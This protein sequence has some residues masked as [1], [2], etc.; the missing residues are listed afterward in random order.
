MKKLKLFFAC[1]LMSILSIG[2]VW[3]TLPAS[4]TWEAQALADIA[5]GSTVIII[6]NSTTA[7]NIALPAAGAGTSNPPK[8]A[9]TV[10]TTDG[11]ST[12][13]PPTGTT[14]QDLAWTLK[15]KTSTWQFFVEGST[16]NCL[17]LTGTS[18]N[19]ALRV[20]EG[21]S[22]NEFVMGDLDKL[23]KVT[24]AAR[25]VG[26]YDNNGSDWRTYNTENATN[27]KGAQL[28]FYVL[29][30]A[31]SC[32][33]TVTITKGAETNGTYTLSAT[34]ICG[35]GEGEDVTIS[36][37]TPDPGYAFDK[38]TTSASG[39]VDNENKKVTGITA[40]T[41]ITV[42]FKELQKYTVSF[43]TGAGNPSQ[44]DITETTAGAGITLPAG[45]T[46][47]C[48]A[49]G[50]VFAGWA[51]AAVA[52]ETTTAPTLLSGTYHPT[53]DI[54]LY[55]VYKKDG[56]S[57][58]SA[59][60][61]ITPSEFTG[62]GDPYTLS[63]DQAAFTIQVNKNSGTKPTVN[64]TAGDAR[65]YAGS[66]MVISNA[67]PMTELVFNIST[68]GKKRLAPITASVGE[69]ATQASG[70]ETVTWTGNATEVTFTVGASADYGSDG[71][72]KAGQLDFDN[73][74]ATAGSSTIYYL[75]APTCCTKHAVNIAAGIEHG[76]VSADPVS[77]C[78]G[79]TITL[80]F[81]PALNYHLSAWTLNGEAQDIAEN[82]FEMPGADVTVSATFAQ[83]ACEPLGTPSVTVSGKAYP[84]DAVQL[85]WTAIEHADAYKVYIYD[86]EDNELEHNDAFAGVEYTIDQ[87]L[88]A[89]TTY[90][91]SVQAIS[92]TPATYCPSTEAASTFTTDALPT[93]H[94]TLIDLEGEHAESG[95]HP[96]LTPFALPTEAASCSKE[97]Y[98]WTSTENY[99]SEDVA[100][101]YK[102]GDNFTFANTTGVTLYAVYADELTPGTTSYVKT[103]LADIASGSEVVV[104]ELYS[105]TIYAIGNDGGTSTGPAAVELAES[106]TDV[107]NVGDNTNIFWV[108]TK[109]GANFSLTVKGGTDKLY[110]TDT[111]NGVRVGTNENNVFSI[112]SDYIF[113]NAT[114][115]YVG[116]NHGS[117]GLFRCYTTINTNINGETLAFYKKTVGEG[118]YGNY[119]TAC[120][121][122][123]EAIVDP[124]EVSATAAAVA[125]GVIEVAYDNVDEENVSVALFSDAA[126][127]EAFDGGWLTASINGD[128]NIAY[129]IAENTTYVARKAYIKL[130]APETNGATDPA[131]VII[132]VEQAGKATVF[133][134]LEDLVA[135]ELASGTE[136]TVSFSNVMI[137]EV[138]ETNAGYRYGLYL[139]VKDKD[140]E[141]DIEL[142]YN[143][144]GDSE[145]VPDTWVKNGYVSATNLVTTWTEYKGQW[146]LAMQ[147][148]T[149]SWENGDITYGAPKAVS[150][151]VVSGEPTKKAYVDGEKFNP[152]GLTVTVNYTVG[153]PE[154]IAVT[155]ADWE[156]TPER[157][158]KGE[159]EISVKATYNT[160]QSAA[161]NVTGLTVGDIQAKTIAEFIANKGGRCYLEGIVNGNI[162]TNF[163]NFDLTD[164]SGTIYVYGSDVF[165][166]NRDVKQGDKVKVIAEEYLL[167]QKA[168]NPDKDEALNVE[169]VSVKKAATV[170]FDDLAMEIEDVATIEPKAI[171][172]AEASAVEY[173]IKDGSDNCI[174]LDGAQI[175]ATAAGTATIVAT[176]AE[177]TA[178]MGTT[179]EFTVTVTEKDTRK[180]A[181]GSAFTAT[182]GD[183]SPA[184]IKFE[185]FKGDNT[186]NNPVINNS[187]IRLYKPLSGTTGN[188][189]TLT[190]K[191]GCKIDQV[192]ITFGGN[193]DAS[194]S[195]D[196]ADFPTTKYITG[197]T[198]LLT[199][200]GLNAQS[201]S[202]VNMKNGSIDVSAIKVWYTGDPLAIDHYILGGTYETTFEQYGAFD[203]TGLQV[204]A[205]YDKEETITEEIFDFTVEADLMTA[206][207]KKAEVYLNE[208]K[209]AEYDITVTQTDK[210]DPEIGWSPANNIVITEGNEFTAPTWQNPHSVSVSFESTNTNVASVSNAG[211]IAIKG[212]GTTTITAT[213]D[214]DETYYSANP[215][216]TVTVNAAVEDLSGDWV[217]ATSVAAGDRIIIA[218]EAEQ[219]AVK[220]M[221]AQN[222]SYREEVAS[223]VD[224][225]N[226]LTP[227]A[228][229]K[230]FTLVDASSFGSYEGFALQASNG[231]YLSSASNSSNNIK[232]VASV[233]DANA[234]WSI[235]ISEGVAA[236]V[237]QGSYTRKVI[238]YNGGSTRFSCYAESNTM[239]DVVIYKKGA[240]PEPV[241]EI[242]RP[243]LTAGNYYT[244]CYNKTMTEI[245]GASLWSFAGKDASMA[246]LVEAEKP[247]AAGTPY[248]IYAESD[249]L[250]A[251][252]EEVP[253]PEAGSNNGLYGTF[254]YMDASALSAA[255]ATYMLYNNALR[256]IGDN[257]HLDANRA[258]VILGNI[259]GGA[260]SAAQVQGR[261][262]RQMP[263]QGQTATGFGELNASETPVKMVINGQLFILRGEKMYD[264]TG[265]LVK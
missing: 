10:S 198:E 178:Y 182:S 258:Y 1:L 216:I 124:E 64:A 42:L 44:A 60:V 113:N 13:T 34:E 175:T 196:G 82:T 156:S 205:A 251:V 193:A 233:S 21:T 245:H 126:C 9:C 22:N 201:V 135:A 40:N 50:W 100:P 180:V 79:A 256:P 125:A 248:F 19:T 211:V 45:P 102:A 153:D 123:P 204:F 166:D 221:G 154:V 236:I 78:E 223:T 46:P 228:G 146:E 129:T 219:G 145:Q 148:A 130:T 174:T 206:G 222:G 6:S 192:Q 136:V 246:Y 67:S 3:A 33:N 214:G 139:N 114:S 140:G 95:D 121:A 17:Y 262:V 203:Y 28:T 93:A 48:S 142:F 225:E 117:G 257:N 157:L 133:A 71:S 260:P 209:I 151:V 235:V 110:C 185:A 58:G 264:V 4:P 51:E 128:K 80:T 244:V 210:V 226:K 255:G 229:T 11:V 98:G 202:I 87:T 224:G 20:G 116:Y 132:P 108:L 177:T 208:V 237:A 212:V 56:G 75:S 243:G 49:D 152:A 197:K 134:S 158:A 26:P 141:N 215:S 165:E 147:G 37:I 70:D 162:N 54:T 161:F 38:I 220:T 90:K 263:L 232:E 227:A 66:T 106:A 249:K 15:K 57:G 53:A 195:V 265:K 55:A 52:S 76:S 252:V 41:T 207:N 155:D 61:T 69:I 259:Q 188:Y 77:A 171:T 194:Y 74:S 16:T 184:D 89:S 96:I 85:A 217:V 63:H 12:I 199:S 92:N 127:T 5:D 200:T 144:Q 254:S 173:F 99:S 118:T 43:N 190:A 234:V 150:S 94:L 65:V 62:D 164:N 72:S 119:S 27:Y 138:Y 14:L 47:A 238:R 24:T 191:V 176:I 131:V 32:S 88:S 23:L 86:N 186:T 112:S 167:Y 261:R 107:L 213:F 143:K 111:N 183:L 187:N 109:D 73:I 104:T 181:T 105:E 137:T 25:F 172:L 103:P 68:Q 239:A 189:L 149:W 159:T 230:V 7:T 169:F 231:N 101:E 84:Y 2:Q 83:D 18:S 31:A 242:V 30:A 115:R 91:Y 97:F 247:Y 240:A 36:A 241:Y 170:T 160:V 120:A 29:K 39:T 250:E 35:D 168:G 81:T 163:G 218:N 253:N 122:A 59:T 8:K 179:A